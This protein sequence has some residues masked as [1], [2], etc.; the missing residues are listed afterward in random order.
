MSDVWRHT[1][2]RTHP[3]RARWYAAM[4][5]CPVCRD[6]KRRA[7]YCDEHGAALTAIE[8][9]EAARAT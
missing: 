4:R 5:S 8:A 9:A 6:A 1:M 3:D 7:D 2:M